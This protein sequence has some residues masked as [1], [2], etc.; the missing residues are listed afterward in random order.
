[1]WVGYGTKG[2]LSLNL[3]DGTTAKYF[4]PD[5]SKIGTFAGFQ[6]RSL[7][8]NDNNIW[9]ATEKGVAI[10]NNNELKTFNRPAKN[11]RTYLMTLFGLYIKIPMLTFGLGLG[12]EV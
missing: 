2:L 6:I 11:I 8:K 9:V 1:M 4:D 12:L 7:I 3:S 10:V 5:L